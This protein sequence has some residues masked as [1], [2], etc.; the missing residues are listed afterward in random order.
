MRSI[1]CYAIINIGTKIIIGSMKPS[2]LLP[3]NDKSELL[4]NKPNN[5]SDRFAKTIEYYI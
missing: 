5:I 1:I 2:R 4:G 3:T